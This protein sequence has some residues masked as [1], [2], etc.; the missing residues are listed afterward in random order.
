MGCEWK[1]QCSKFKVLWNKI[2]SQPRN[3]HSCS[4]LELQTPVVSEPCHPLEGA[5][6]RFSVKESAASPGG[7]SILTGQVQSHPGD[8]VSRLRFP[9]CRQSL[10]FWMDVFLPWRENNVLSVASECWEDEW[11]LFGRHVSPSG[12]QVEQLEL[13]LLF[14][15][16]VRFAYLSLKPAT[17][18]LQNS[19]VNFSS[20]V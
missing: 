20:V 4:M 13:E 10:G 2:K 16:D 6:P 9:G 7:Q 5:G 19:E 17:C 15:W 18:W 11:L 12:L 14:L 3:E 1:I 8:G